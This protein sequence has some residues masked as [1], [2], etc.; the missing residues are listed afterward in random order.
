MPVDESFFFL[1]SR[2]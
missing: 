2:I 1:I